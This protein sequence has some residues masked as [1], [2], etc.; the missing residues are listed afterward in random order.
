MNKVLKR[1]IPLLIAIILLVYVLKD[2][3]FKDI[4]S[5][6]KKTNY[7]YILLASIITCLSYYLRGWRWQQ[8]LLALGYKPT[9]F[10]ATIAMQSGSVASMIIIGSGEMTRCLTLQRTDNIPFSH[11]IGSIVA[12]RVIDTIMLLLIFFIAF[13]LEVSRMSK[14]VSGLTFSTSGTVLGLVLIVG[15]IASG[16]F[17]LLWRHPYIRKKNF[18]EK[19]NRFAKGLWEGFAA[20]RTLPNSLLFI[21]LTIS[22]QVLGWLG[23]YCLMLSSE[24]TRSLT[25]TA[26]LTVLAVASLGG[27]AV[28]TQGGIG[29]YHVLVSR[30]LVLYGLTTAE[31]AIVATF[32]HA[33]G[34]A[35]NLVLSSISFLI[36]PVLI[37][38][39]NKEVA[40]EAENE[41]KP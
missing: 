16:L 40:L 13:V 31:G 38:R 30:A 3:G 33:V 14:Y 26:A 41:P 10:R 12:E 23:I 22:I 9:A 19:I 20:I 4:I 37:Q 32:M 1:S 17:Y 28:P 15:L 39:R 27:F 36:I 7:I 5:Q 8:P 29:T 34:F 35:I 25:P 2:I 18:T 6:F 24:I 11:T 21:F